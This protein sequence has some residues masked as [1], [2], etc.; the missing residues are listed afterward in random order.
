MSIEQNIERLYRLKEII[1][2]RKRGIAPIIPISASTWYDGIKT[3]RFPEGTKISARCTVWRKS[4]IDALVERL[5][6]TTP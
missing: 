3:G 5:A 6:Q 1:G 4:V 2:D